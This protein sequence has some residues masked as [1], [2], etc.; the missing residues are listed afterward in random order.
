MPTHHPDPRP[1]SCRNGASRPAGVLPYTRADAIT[2]ALLFEVPARLSRLF[3]FTY[4]VAVTAQAWFD[5]VHWDHAAERGK[6]RPTGETEAGRITEVLWAARQAVSTCPTGSH[7]IPF[8]VHRVPPTGPVTRTTRLTLQISIHQ[9]DHGETVATIGHHPA[10]IAGRFHLPD[11]AEIRWPAAAFDH[12]PQGRVHP[13]VTADTLDAVLAAVTQIAGLCV[14]DVSPGL[15][16]DLHV[17]C[18]DGSTVTLRPDEA[19]RYHLRALR[20]PFACEPNPA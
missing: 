18:T 5:A 6:P 20:L 16:E 2:D 14:S 4:P 9:G 3:R 8:T 7:D 1:P 19:G 13:V 17:F 10:P 12:D 11:T 15:D